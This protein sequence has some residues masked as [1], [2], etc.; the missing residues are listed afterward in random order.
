MPKSGD[1]LAPT[2]LTPSPAA[3]L[4]ARRSREGAER[5]TDLLATERFFGLEWTDQESFDLAA[6]EREL[7]L[8][9]SESPERVHATPGTGFAA[10]RKASR[11][12]EREI[13]EIS[14]ERDASRIAPLAADKA[15]EGSPQE[16]G[17]P[18]LLHVYDVSEH[19]YVQWVNVMFAHRWSPLKFGGF[20]HVGVEVYGVEWTFGYCTT[21]AGVALN[22]PRKHPGHHFR[23]TLPVGRTTLSRKDVET[24]MA[25]LAGEYPGMSYSLLRKNCCHFAEDLIGRMGL[26][27]IPAWVHR[28]ASIGDQTAGVAETVLERA[29]IQHLSRSS[30]VVPPPC[31]QTVLTSV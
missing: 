14:A 28:L 31:T 6:L 7:G 15:T 10:K 11:R 2:L 26:G 30:C 20:F 18:V 9:W 24:L 12:E 17:S 19:A 23:E 5:D 1:A 25:T 13:T 21:G 4:K 22:E 8:E 27:P 16:D 3:A 29:G